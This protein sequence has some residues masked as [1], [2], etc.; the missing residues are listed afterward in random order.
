MGD[1]KVRI[2]SLRQLFQELLV[3]RKEEEI[4]RDKRNIKEAQKFNRKRKLSMYLCR[5]LGKVGVI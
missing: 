4:W 3:N 5:R 2:M 1:E